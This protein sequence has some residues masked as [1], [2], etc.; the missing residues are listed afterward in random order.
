MQSLLV[1]T[2]PPRSEEVSDLRAKL[3]E[4]EAALTV[5]RRVNEN[6]R[7]QL[8]QNRVETEE[9]RRLRAENQKLNQVIDNFRGE[10]ARLKRDILENM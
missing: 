5:E 9:L 4:A 8:A 6:L 10:H 7:Q 1:K 2:R 3:R